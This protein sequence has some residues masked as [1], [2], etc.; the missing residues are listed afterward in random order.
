LT[1]TWIIYNKHQ[2]KSW[3]NDCFGVTKFNLS[4]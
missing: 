4:I 1:S 3:T 2:L